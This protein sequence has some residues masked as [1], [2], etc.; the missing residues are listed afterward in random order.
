MF[1]ELL[2][3]ISWEAVLRDCIGKQEE[4]LTEGRDA[5]QKDME[6][7]YS[8]GGE[9]LEQLPREAVGAPSLEVQG[10]VG[11]GPG[12]SELVGGSP[13]YGTG[14]DWVGFVVCSNP[15]QSMNL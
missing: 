8:E 15:S 1:K 2:N 12:Q 7:L 5:I 3:Q 6:I 13:A 4:D 10:Q 9:A 11:W 14:W